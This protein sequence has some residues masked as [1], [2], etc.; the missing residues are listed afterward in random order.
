[1]QEVS[2]LDLV[3]QKLE[4]GYDDEDGEMKNKLLP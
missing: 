4:M 2:A 3:A 1:V